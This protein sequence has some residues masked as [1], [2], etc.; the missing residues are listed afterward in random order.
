ML[1]SVSGFAVAGAVFCR[2]AAIAA[3]VVLGD[4]GLEVR[5]LLLEDDG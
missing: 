3:L 2:L 4:I 5:L 1:V